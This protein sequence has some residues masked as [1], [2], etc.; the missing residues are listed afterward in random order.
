MEPVIPAVDGALSS[1]LPIRI[2]LT[3]WPAGV[4]RLSG[5]GRG[6]VVRPLGGR[7]GAAEQTWIVVVLDAE[8]D[9]REAVPGFSSMEAADAYA[10][11]DPDIL[12]W[13]SV[14]SRPAIPD[15]KSGT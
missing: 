11:F 5:T 13:R 9:P 15:R 8:G 12:R 3:T 4:R 10:E 2:P 7:A 1:P 14:P 6:H